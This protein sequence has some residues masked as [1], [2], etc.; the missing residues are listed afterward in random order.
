MN[1]FIKRLINWKVCLL[2]SGLFLLF[3]LIVLPSES[4][5]SELL[6]GGLA[7][8]D[9]EFFYSAEFLED[10]VSGYS[11]EAREEYVISKIRF[12]IL[13]PLVYGIWLTS[14]IGLTIKGIKRTGG[15]WEKTIMNRLPLLPLFAVVFD[16]L[17]N[18]AVS[19]VMRTYPDTP[20]EIL[21]VA[22]IFSML[23]WIALMGSILIG[24][25]LLLY[26]IIRILKRTPID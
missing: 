11:P 19:I 23:K 1:S 9:T 13:W 4:S 26:Y 17:E 7:S 8:P 21:G 12:D 5:K 15:L 3:L 2:F 6:T 10:L 18:I 20:M 25:V 16:L 22:P 24:A 14:G